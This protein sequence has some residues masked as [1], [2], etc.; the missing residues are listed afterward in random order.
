MAP[1]TKAWE[2]ERWQGLARRAA[3]LRQDC[4]KPYRRTARAATDLYKSALTLAA[5][6]LRLGKQLRD[7]DFAEMEIE[8]WFSDMKKLEAKEKVSAEPVII[9]GQ[10]GT[11]SC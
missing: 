4:S 7:K 5:A 2:R 9:L 3:E 11:G 1:A 6:E 8:A 10:A